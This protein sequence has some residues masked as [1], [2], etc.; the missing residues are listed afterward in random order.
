MLELRSAFGIILGSNPGTTFTD[1]VVTLIG[2]KLNLVDYAQP[3][4]ATGAFCT[5]FLTR[6]TRPYFYGNLLSGLGLLLMG[7]SEMTGGFVSL[8]ETVDIS[9]FQ[10]HNLFFYFITGTIFTAIIESSSAAMMIVLSALNAEVFTL[11]EL[12]A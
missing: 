6:E 9:L 4:L 1:W 5:V 10:G 3:L 8:S 11:Q 7:L 2:F 12:S